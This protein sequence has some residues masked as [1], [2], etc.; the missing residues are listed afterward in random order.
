MHATIVQLTE[1]RHGWRNHIS[2]EDVF[3]DNQDRFYDGVEE[4]TGDGFTEDAGQFCETLGDV[5]S[6]H[7]TE[8]DV[9]RDVIWVDIDVSKAG[10][11]FKEPFSWFRKAVSRL[12]GIT[13]DMFIRDPHYVAEVAV[14]AVK[15][16]YYFDCM[17]V[18]NE[19]GYAAPISEWLRR[20]I[21]ESEQEGAGI[22][23]RF[24]LH[25]SYDGNQ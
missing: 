24:Y 9:D 23:R 8:K 4:R 6:G 17:Y 14:Y 15:E 18:M 5:I 19:N 21:R 3:S 16:A 1:D 12:A 13:E 25:A 11:L 22:V 10:Q 7:G 2:A 20:L